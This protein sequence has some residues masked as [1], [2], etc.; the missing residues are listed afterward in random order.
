LQ[1]TGWYWSPEI[2]AAQRGLGADIIKVHDLWVARCECN[3]RFYDWVPDLYDERRRVGSSTRGHPLKLGLASLYGKKAQRSGRGPYHDA[4]EAGLITAMTRAQL[5]EAVAQDPEAVVM[6]AT[7]AVFSTRPL[8][9]DIGE[10]LGQWELKIWPDL[11]IAQPGVYWSP[12][13]I[14]TSV[15]SRGVRRSVISSATPKFQQAFR[16]WAELMRRPGAMELML[17][18]RQLIPSVPVTIRV[19]YGCRL[20][21]ARSKPWLAGTWKDET[22]YESFEW[23]T[24]R[25][26]LRV[27]F[28]DD[29]CLVTFPLSISA[30]TESKGHEPADFDRLVEIAGDGGGNNRRNHAA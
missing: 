13:D 20:A 6:L 24:K 18:E 15:K 14:Q 19:F 10:G 16:D 22:R 26:P 5:I 12:S 1:G 17:K 25:D 2:E 9:L 21:L 27:S 28:D 3:C 30:F 4:V 11:F 23:G 8:P 7:D 29:G